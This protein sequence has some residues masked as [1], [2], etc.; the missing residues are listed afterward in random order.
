[1]HV[2]LAAAIHS[3]SY[4][5][6]ISWAGHIADVCILARSSELD[7]DVVLR[8][9]LVRPMG[10]LITDLRTCSPRVRNTKHE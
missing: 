9:P 2:H 6:V 7:I 4:I 5:N 3:I 10:A 8:V 1:M